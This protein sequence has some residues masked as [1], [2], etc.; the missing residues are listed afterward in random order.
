MKK[1]LFILAAAMAVLASCKDE[2]PTLSINI[3]ELSF[4]GEASTQTVELSS[5][6][7]WTATNSNDWITVSPMSGTGNQTI[8]VSVTKDE[9]LDRS[10]TVTFSIGGLIQTLTVKQACF[11]TYEVDPVALTFNPEGGTQ[12]VNVSSNQDWT[13]EGGADWIKVDPASGS[14]SAS[15]NALS[16][17]AAPNDGIDREASFKVSFNSGDASITVSVKQGGTA[18][19]Y[20]GVVYKTITMKDG[21][22]WMASPLKYIPE[23][24]TPSSDP[25]DGSGFWYAYTSDGTTCTPVTDGSAGYLYDY[26]T[27]FGAEVNAENYK[28]F[29]GTRGICPEG[30]HIPTRAEF[31]NLVGNSVKGAGE[32]SELIK[33]DAA[34]YD[35]EYK[36]GRISALDADGFGW[37][38]LGC[39]NVTNP[40]ALDKGSYQKLICDQA[41][42][43]VEGYI[44]KNRLTY[45]M[46]STGNSVNASNG[47]I[48][49]FG[50]MSTFTKTYPEGR[51]HAAFAN[52]R[53]GFE[54]RCI[55]D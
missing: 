47:N 16:V 18:I 19:E 4:Q 14:A 49:F 33:E 44:G 39:V 6:T 29:E 41:T 22:T 12:A 38:F 52:Y 25:T 32:D 30:W 28:G 10:G 48:Q 50:L 15:G 35:E 31:V 37:S 51:L 55:K 11:P 23:G 3:Q 43:S 53:S 13:I 5:N 20:G 9:G 34:Y 1:I 26:P 7:S 17:T 24:K 54:V 36:G 46:S 8:K 2:D 27:A 21:R 45:V 42:C 40:N